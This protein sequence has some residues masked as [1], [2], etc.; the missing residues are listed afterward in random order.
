MK[1]SLNISH[2]TV[3]WLNRESLHATEHVKVHAYGVLGKYMG[4][5]APDRHCLAISF[6]NEKVF[7]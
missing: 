1:I 4:T 3:Q 5:K 6:I 2:Y 7:H